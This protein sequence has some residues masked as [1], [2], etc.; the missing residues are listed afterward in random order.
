[1]TVPIST[2]ARLKLTLLGNALRRSI[3]QTIGFVFG[4]VYAASMVLGAVAVA[5]WGNLGD[6]T[7]VAE[8][9]VL[10][11]ALV[12]AGWWLLPIF[13]YG[14]DATLDPQRF[15]LYPLSRG[16]LLGGLTMAGLVSIPAIATLFALLALA[17]M[18]ASR[19]LVVFLLALLGV[20]LAFGICLVGSRALTT[21]L[22][23]L[24]EGRRTREALT[25]V[26]FLAILAISPLLTVLTA[27]FEE[28]GLSPAALRGLLDEIATNAGWTPLGAPWGMARSA[29]LGDW[30][31]AG[32]QFLIALATLAALFALWA[33]G[34]GRVL[35][36]P[37]TGSAKAEKAKGLGWFARFPA[38]PTGAVAARAATYWFRDPRYSISLLAVVSIPVIFFF[39]GRV[40]DG[41]IVSLMMLAPP[42][43]AWVM[44][45]SIANDVASDYTAF[46]LHVAV[47]VPGRA[48]RWGRLIPV[49]VVGLPLT[50]A[51]CVAASWVTGHWAWLPAILGV[52]LCILG[53]S[54][55]IGSAASARWLYPMVKPGESPLKQPQGA[56]M[57]S[58]VSLGVQ[59]GLLGLVLLPA[60]ALA[61]A[62]V[63]LSIVS[64]GALVLTLGLAALVVGAAVG[65]LVLIGGVRWG[66]RALERRAPEILQQVTNFP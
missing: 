27:H 20:V 11:G 53:A 66:A 5:L 6:V 7:T 52:T 14:V 55:G 63:V 1:M 2:F 34:I 22:A 56:A 61:I 17:G 31:T 59:V 18:W 29:Y 39:A 40:G 30:G 28:T 32:W 47:G 44:G 58:M 43:V 12:V 46:A 54:L 38:T 50:V 37:R 25:V 21:V 16:R 13:L 60:V 48:D 64:P 15:A 41:E 26:G 4:V 24:M 8:V 65:L 51:L 23:P 10:I 45:V 3:W 42:L 49:A 57:A 9:V 33:W 19:S 36:N 62:S 35:T